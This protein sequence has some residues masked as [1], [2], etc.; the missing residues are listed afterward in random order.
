MS[1]LHTSRTLTTE[2]TKMPLLGI[3]FGLRW[4][5]NRQ[6][7]WMALDENVLEKGILNVTPSLQ[8]VN[9]Q[10]PQPSF[11]H[12]HTLKIS[13]FVSLLPN[14]AVMAV[15]KV[16]GSP[17][18]TA[19]MRVVSALYE[20]G[21]Q[22]E[23]V[24]ID[25]KVGQHKSEAF[26]ALNVSWIEFSRDHG[27]LFA[28]VLLEVVWFRW[29]TSEWVLWDR[30]FHVMFWDLISREATSHSSYSWHEFIYHWLI[31]FP[32]GP[33]C[34]LHM[35]NKHLFNMASN[36]FCSRLKPS[37]KFFFIKT[38]NDVND[39]IRFAEWCS[40]LVKFQPLKT[41]TWS[42]SVKSPHQLPFLFSEKENCNRRKIVK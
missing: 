19:T 13:L 18:S 40:H 34:P 38:W 24:S 9:T 11:L 12:S 39:K 23:F 4:I 3:L 1:W 7:H 16:H 36:D 8:T 37:T 2:M 17:F 30:V 26:L 35:A 31:C 28:N 21:L 33:N 10:A 22:F 5:W 27:K 41:E 15:L 20:K 29:P 25:M 6:K 32:K 14:P 42:S